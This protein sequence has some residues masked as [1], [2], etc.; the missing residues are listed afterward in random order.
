MPKHQTTRRAMSAAFLFF[1][2][3]LF[4]AATLPQSMQ[5]QAAHKTPQYTFKVINIFPHDSEAFTQGL[6]YRGGFQ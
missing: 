3:V 6:E 1:S 2:E 4:L 5:A